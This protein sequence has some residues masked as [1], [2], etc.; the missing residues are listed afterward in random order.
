M[1]EKLLH[2][3]RKQKKRIRLHGCAM[4]STF[5]DKH[6]NNSRSQL[7]WFSLRLALVCSFVCLFAIHQFSCCVCYVSFF[8]SNLLQQQT[9][10]S[11]SLSSSSSF[12]IHILF[13]FVLLRCALLFQTRKQQDIEKRKEKYEEQ[14]RRNKTNH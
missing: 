13:I 2:C 14:N 9:L 8:F 3:P 1:C 6:F 12:N 5:D 7:V 10:M 4:Y 11:I